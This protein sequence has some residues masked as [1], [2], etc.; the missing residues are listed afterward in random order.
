MKTQQYQVGQH[1]IEVILSWVKT[2]DMAI[3]EIQR[4]FVWNKTKVRN[5]IDS[6]YHGYPVGYLIAWRNPNIK[7]KDGTISAGKKILIDGQQRV[8]ALTTAILGQDIINKDY[9][10]ERIQISFHPI[11]E[12]FEVFNPAI[13]KDSAWIDDIANIV[14]DTAIAI[15]V[16]GEYCKSNP[17]AKEEQVI[18]SISNLSQI[19]HKTLGFIELE[20]ELDI[21]T[22]NVIFERVNSTGVQLSQADFAMSKI[23]AH[24]DFGSMLRKFIDYF[25]H[26]AEVPDF[27]DNLSKTDKEFSKSPYLQKIAWLRN[28]RDDLYD[29]KYADLLRV[30]FTSEFNRGKLSDLVSL[31]SGRNFETRVCEEII[32]EDTFKRLEQSVLRFTNETN[33]KRFLMIIRSSGFITSR[34]IQSQN[35][36]NFAYILFLKLRDLGCNPSKIE[37]FVKKWFVMSVLTGRYSSSSESAFDEDV[38]K[39]TS[40]FEDQIDYIEKTELTDAFWDVALVQELEK[41]NTNSPFLSVFFAS[42]IKDNDRGFLSRDITV[43]EIVSNKGDIHHIF[44]KNFLKKRFNKKRDYNQIS[45]LAYT[46]TDI[47]IPIKDKPPSEYFTAVIGQCQGGE[48]EYGRITD[49]DSLKENMKQ[50]CIPDNTDKMNLDDYLDFLK[51]RRVL[52]AKKIKKYYQSL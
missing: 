12:E 8:T 52:M 24:G 25:C 13:E 1:D 31:L 45:N 9:G 40:D 50:N 18:K 44:P 10:K 5:F 38:K 32:K 43:R 47:N 26:L 46:Q 23:A 11:K 17:A 3:P 14:N 20:A 49:M 41:S 27:Y 21:E 19:A 6:L 39:I 42:Q 28:E 34:F 48:L 4:P 36:L 29:P 33:F 7:M 35:T 15:Q 51:Q 37:Q 22:V 30:A 16:I 2:K